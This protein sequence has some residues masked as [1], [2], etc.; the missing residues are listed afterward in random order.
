M[1]GN[2]SSNATPELLMRQAL[3]DAGVNFTDQF[4]A[5]RCVIDFVAVGGNSKV[6]LF[7]DGCYWHRCPIHRSNPK[8]NAEFWQKKFRDNVRRDVRNSEACRVRGFTVYRVWE[9]RVRVDA[10]GVAEIVRA[11]LARDARPGII[12]L[13]FSGTLKRQRD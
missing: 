11:A 8:A 6:A 4:R 2:K 7:V 1:Q 12:H 9:C 5:G 13:K 3:T 10:D